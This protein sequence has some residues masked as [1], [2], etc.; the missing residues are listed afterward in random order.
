MD[1]DGYILDVFQLLLQRILNLNINIKRNIFLK[2][3]AKDSNS[4]FKQGKKA[5]MVFLGRLFLI[6][7]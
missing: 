1:F 2:I 4:N 3:R 7:K 5:P 6:L